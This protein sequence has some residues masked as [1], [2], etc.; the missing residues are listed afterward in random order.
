MLT[1]GSTTPCRWDT[2][3]AKRDTIDPLRIVRNLSR[4]IDI[5]ARAIALRE[6]LDIA[7][8]RAIDERSLSL[9]QTIALTAA[10]GTCIERPV[11]PVLFSVQTLYVFC[12]NTA[13]ARQRADSNRK[14]LCIVSLNEWKRKKKKG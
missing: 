13:F 10:N 4:S 12:A 14:D 9:G 3:F 5:V 11:E 2:R 7:S 6:Q 8:G 1:E